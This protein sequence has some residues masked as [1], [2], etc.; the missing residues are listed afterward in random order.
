MVQNH[1]WGPPLWRLLHSLAE[2]LGRQAVPLLAQDE[3]RAWLTVLQGV[4]GIMPCQLCRGHYRTWR[5]RRPLEGL[6][7]SADASREWI[8]SLHE[9]VNDQKGVA[10]E[11]RIPFAQL[12]EVYGPT[13]R[14]RVEIQQDVETLVNVLGRAALER[15]VNGQ[16]VREWRQ[17]LGTLR[18]L[19]NV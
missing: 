1:E 12:T 16:V 18:R 5:T 8:W 4:E 7:G 2:R 14:G 17:K 10:A 9:A 15:Q 19:L 6:F 11:G 3:F 13:R